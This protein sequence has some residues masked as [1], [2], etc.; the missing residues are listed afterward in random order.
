MS[1]N[2]IR[3]RERVRI[4]KERESAIINYQAEEKRETRRKIEKERRV[5]K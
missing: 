3:E 5:N 4:K 1:E 2:K